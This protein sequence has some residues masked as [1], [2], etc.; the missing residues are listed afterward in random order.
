[1]EQDYDVIVLGTGLKECILSG[2]MGINKQKVLHMDRNPYYGGES[3]SLN[4]EQLYKKFRPDEKVPN[5]MGRTR[6]YN[7]DLCPK[8][9]MACGNLVKVLLHTKVTR[10]LEFKSVAGGY[11]FKDGKVHKVPSTASEALNSDLMGFM[12]KRR[13]RNFINYVNAWDPNDAKTHEGMDL[14]KVKTKAL[15][16]HFSLDGDTILFTGHAL[17]LWYDDAYLE[18]PARETVEKVKLYAYSVS[19][20]GNSPYIYPVWGLGG[21]PEGFSRLGAIHGGT[22]MLNKPVEEILYDKNG[23]V[24]GVKSEGKVANCKKLIGDPSYF[25]GS[26]KIKKVG[27]I[28]RCICILSHPIRDTNNSDSCQI[29]LPAKSVPNRKN[30]IYISCVS[31]HHQIAAKGKY[32]AVVSTVVESKDPKT[33]MAPAIKLLDKIDQSFFWVTDSYIPCNDPTKDQSYI[34]SSYDATTHFEQSTLEVLDMYFKLMGKPL[35]LT[36]SAEPDDLD[37]AN[38]AAADQAAAEAAAA[39]AKAKEKSAAAASTSTAASSAANTAAAAP[40]ASAAPP[41]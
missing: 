17:A 7:V 28:A 23:V 29:I 8:F 40:T 39:E 6:D 30:D 12:S 14:N 2:L 10:Y 16:D 4:L 37:P 38:Q 34:T 36:I 26:T 9:L 41:K 31:Y 35:D 1:M 32:I 5:D 18:Q 24:T 19:R 33:E 22:F 25:I 11:V 20:Y 21:L 13:F 27:Q 15:F 3:A